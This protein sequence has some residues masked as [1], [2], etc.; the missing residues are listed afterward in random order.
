MRYL[1]LGCGGVVLPKP[2]ENLDARLLAGIDHQCTADDLSKFEEATFD[3]VYASHI[4]EHFTRDKTVDVVKEWVRV[5]K[6]DGILRVSVPSLK[7]MIEIYQKTHN[8]DDVIGPMY[9]GQTYEQNF[10]YCIFDKASLKLLMEKCGLVAVHPW[11]YTRTEHSDY[12]DFSQALT[13]GILI[14]LNLEGRKK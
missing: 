1:H 13:Q 4:L 7:S 10:H 14:S 6:K 3:L 9:G 12:W 11:L 8:I 2:F 5:L